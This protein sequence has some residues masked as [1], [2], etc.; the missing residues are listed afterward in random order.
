[1]SNIK[2]QA[3]AFFV[4]IGLI[5]LLIGCSVERSWTVQELA[6]RYTISYHTRDSKYVTGTMIMRKNGTYLQRFSVDGKHKITN[7]GKWE[8]FDKSAVV[9]DDMLYTLDDSG[10]EAV[11]NK[12]THFLTQPAMILGRVIIGIGEVSYYKVR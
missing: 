4:A 7:H 2:Y 1:M 6:G 3:A 10:R 8:I 12:R 9:W 5:G 11:P